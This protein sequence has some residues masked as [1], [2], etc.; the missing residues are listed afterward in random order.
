MTDHEPP[1]HYIQVLNES[2]AKH[3]DIVDNDDDILHAYIEEVERL[4]Q[5]GML[6]TDIPPD[7]E[8]RRDWYIRAAQKE[9]RRNGNAIKKH[10]LKYEE[11]QQ[12]LDLGTDYESTITVCNAETLNEFYGVEDEYKSGR[13]VTLGAFASVDLLLMRKQLEIVT[14]KVTTRWRQ[15]DPR[16]IASAQ[17]LAHFTN[18]R[19][20]RA[21]S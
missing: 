15:L 20:Y 13:K 16:Y 18:Y 8:L 11:H 5:E 4:E 2:T 1:I 14:R 6:R 10:H 3:S 12:A 21:A 17:V 19:D 7:E 9:G